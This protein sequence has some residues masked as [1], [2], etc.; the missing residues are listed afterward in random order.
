MK[1]SKHKN[2]HNSDPWRSTE[3]ILGPNFAQWCRPVP[4]RLPRTSFG[5][6][7]D[8][9]LE[10]W[11]NVK[12]DVEIVFVRWD[13]D[14]NDSCHSCDNFVHD[15]HLFL[16]AHNDFYI[17]VTIVS[18][19]SLVHLPVFLLTKLTSILQSDECAAPVLTQ[20]NGD[21]CCKNELDFLYFILF[22]EDASEQCIKDERKLT[23]ST[24]ECFLWLAC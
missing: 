18:P 22:A 11:E 23:Y 8:T 21:W 5:H 9:L 14:L 12:K 2:A 20:N 10:V 13:S 1:L 6:F 16:Y 3:L 24:A 17:V 15:Y 7:F 4:R 19:G